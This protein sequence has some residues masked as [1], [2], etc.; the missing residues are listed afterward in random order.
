MVSLFE[1]TIISP[2]EISAVNFSPSDMIV[3]SN[4][5]TILPM[6]YYHP[7]LP[8]D[9]IADLPGSGSDTF[10]V[11]TQETLGLI[12]LPSI[13]AAV[14]DAPQVWFVIFQKAIDEYQELGFET[15]PHLTWLDTHYQR[16]GVETW[17]DLL[18]FFYTTNDL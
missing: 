12:A 14:G 15:H 1:W 9:F 8:Q 5:L 6:V 7:D 18:L 10:A 13:E 4:K 17:G 2:G 3:H 11:P 16:E